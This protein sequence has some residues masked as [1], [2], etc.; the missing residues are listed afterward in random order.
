MSQI[1]WVKA[2]LKKT[3][4]AI[5]HFLHSSEPAKTKILLCS[6]MEAKFIA[7]ALLLKEEG[8]EVHLVSN[9]PTSLK[10]EFLDQI[11]TSG[12]HFYDNS[13]MTFEKSEEFIS[14]IVNENQFDFIFD[15]G[16]HTY[17]KMK[18]ENER[19][20]CTEFTQ[21][22]I[23]IAKEQK[24]KVPLINLNSSITKSLVGNV[25]GTGI[26]ALTAIQTITNI[27]FHGLNVGIVGFGPVG[28]S[29]ALSFKG[30]N[31]T[32][33]S[34]DK[35][36]SKKA[37]AEKY[38]ISFV[39]KE[40]LLKKCDLIITCTGRS[41]VISPDDSILLRDGCILA[42]VGHYNHEI[43]LPLNSQTKNITENIQEFHFEGKSVY[44]LSHGNLVNLAFGQGYPIQI[45]DLSLAAAIYAWVH[46]TKNHYPIGLYGYPNDLDVKY[47]QKEI[48]IYKI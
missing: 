41:S 22:G 37:I 4:E 45:I 31:A 38:G 29:C 27:S 13:K 47:F 5:Q 48:E 24:L 36:A 15:D 10:V 6:H 7:F 21:S 1:D 32:V 33:Y 9:L 2:R 8:Y 30:A 40:T 43:S 20:I 12:V 35:N 39:D 44:L 11:K 23:N 42:N 34:Y 28:L 17:S 3:Q 46:F 18:E 14:Q 19:C 25:H 16:G 26:S